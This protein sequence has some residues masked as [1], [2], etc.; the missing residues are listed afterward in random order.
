MEYKKVVQ[1]CNPGLATLSAAS[2]LTSFSPSSVL[3]ISTNR[4]ASW[5]NSA[6]VRLIKV[7]FP[8]PLSSP[9]TD[10]IGP[11][12]AF[13]AAL[14]L[15]RSAPLSSEGDRF[16]D[17]RRSNA[18]TT[19]DANGSIIREEKDG[20]SSFALQI[21]DFLT[22][23]KKLDSLRKHPRSISSMSSVHPFPMILV[24]PGIFLGSVNASVRE[25]KEV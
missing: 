25:E 2:A 3:R 21:S 7:S 20:R 22:Y 4:R 8:L 19:W 1:T 14:F 15:E 10:F 24:Q 6:G 18:R 11:C 23:Q 12:R 16:G 13:Q 17:R 9:K 5:R